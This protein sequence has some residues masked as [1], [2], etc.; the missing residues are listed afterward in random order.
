MSDD[1]PCPR[2]AVTP[3]EP[4]GI[5][6]DILVQAI[7]HPLPAE[8]IAIAEP[9]LLTERARL[10]NLPL[11]L[12]H[13]DPARP[14]AIRRPGYLQVLP[15]RHRITG[16]PG[17]PEPEDAGYI[18]E[19]LRTACAGC[20]DGLFAALVTAPVH[21]ASLNRAGQPFS[22]HTEYLA[23]VCGSG[24]PV[25]MLANNDLRIALVTTHLP[26][27]EVSRSITAGRLE[28]VLTVVWHELR[29]RFRIAA[30]RLQVCGL[31]P[32]AGEEGYLGREEVQTI[33]PVLEKLRRQGMPLT[34]PVPADTAFTPDRL[35]HTDATICM[36][37]DQG[38]PVLKAR[39]FGDTVNITLGLPILRTSVDHGTALSLAG[40]GRS[41]CSSLLAAIRC[42]VDLAAPA[43]GKEQP[44]RTAQRV[45]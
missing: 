22:G 34:G 3:G 20:L 11:S 38:L 35:A 7:Q 16:R 43:T 15:V 21:K 23:E 37:H 33:I 36:Y 30:P 29:T 4:A 17:H 12:D 42:A 19:T 18:L 40:T 41:R 31:N 39:G 1:I 44:P 45:L 13:F 9:D 25:M 10:L 27:A 8:I 2:L 28:T 5:G 26:L 14:P 32:H 6:P 24:Q